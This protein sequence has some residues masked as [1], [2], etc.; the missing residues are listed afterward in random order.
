MST[1]GG[2]GITYLIEHKGYSQGERKDLVLDTNTY[3]PCRGTRPYLVRYRGPG[4]SIGHKWKVL[5]TDT[6]PSY[7]GARLYLARYRVPDTYPP[8]R[9]TRLYLARYR[10][11]GSCIWHV[12]HGHK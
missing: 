12:S 2:M 3:P 1:N 7:R 6:Y 11:P 8:C 4:S 9:G 10:G 5:D